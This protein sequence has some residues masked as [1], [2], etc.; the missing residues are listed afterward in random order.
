M[1]LWASG[2]CFWIIQ[3]YTRVHGRTRLIYCVGLKKSII[4]STSD[5][6]RRESL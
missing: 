4:G 6:D 1:P 2:S 5:T 3:P